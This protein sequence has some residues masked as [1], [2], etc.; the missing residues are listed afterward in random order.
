M[1]GGVEGGEGVVG[2]YGP[3]VLGCPGA[4]MWRSS[5]WLSLLPLSPCLLLQWDL[6]LA[7]N[8]AGV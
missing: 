3:L 7:W 5:V 6:K 2:G 4:R 8:W 1:R